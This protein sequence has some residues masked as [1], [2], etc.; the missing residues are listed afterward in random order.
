MGFSGSFLTGISYLI[1]YSSFLKSIFGLYYSLG[2]IFGD[3]AFYTT[4]VLYW[5]D[6]T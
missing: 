5:T 1:L 6:E 4:F 2:Y 3:W